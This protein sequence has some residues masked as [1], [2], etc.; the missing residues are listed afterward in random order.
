MRSCLCIPMLQPCQ[1]LR[2][3]AILSGAEKMHYLRLSSGLE[4][5]LNQS[6]ETERQLQ[7]EL[8]EAKQVGR[9]QHCGEPGRCGQV[10]CC[11]DFALQPARATGA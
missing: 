8:G 2:P 7:Q 6:Q 5:A 11:R 9:R 10:R 4:S 1:L 3:P